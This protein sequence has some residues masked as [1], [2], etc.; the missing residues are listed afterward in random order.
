MR[1]GQAEGRRGS[2][3]SEHRRD[4]GAASASA[5]RS[6]VEQRR[7][8]GAPAREDPG[9]GQGGRQRRDR[10]RLRRRSIQRHARPH[11]TRPPRRWAGSTR[12]ST[13]PPSA[14]SSECPR[15][16]RSSGSRRSPPTSSAP[17][18]SAR[19]R[20]PT[21]SKSVGNVI[22]MSTTGASYT[23]PWGGLSVYQVSKAALNRLAEHWRVEQPGINFTV[24]TIGECGG[25]AGRCPVAFQR[26]LGHGTDGCLRR[27][28]VRPQPAQRVV[29][30]R[31]APHRPARM[32]SSRRAS[33]SRCRR[34]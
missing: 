7:V 2:S 27:R 30:R 17:A 26:R 21:S 14:R 19:R 29:H 31:R 12:S 22:Y 24:V 5:S 23:P 16:R 34:W 20:S 15:R 6:G 11:S 4:S 10:H 32:R 3:S 9:S 8:D 1:T 28:L 33:R 25:R 18:T 13:P